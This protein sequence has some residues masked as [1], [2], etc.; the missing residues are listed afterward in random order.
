MLVVFST[1]DYAVAAIAR[2]QMPKGVPHADVPTI[3]PCLEQ[4]VFL[5]V[6]MSDTVLRST[7]VRDGSDKNGE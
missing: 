7:Q 6:G 2:M 3:A 4:E 1:R 5:S